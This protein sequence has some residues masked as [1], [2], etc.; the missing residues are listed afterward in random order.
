MSNYRGDNRKS[1]LDFELRVTVIFLTLGSIS[2]GYLGWGVLEATGI[3]DEI[4]ANHSQYAIQGG[5]LISLVLFG[6][7][8]RFSAANNQGRSATVKIGGILWFASTAL[9][10]LMVLSFAEMTRSTN[11]DWLQI[12]GYSAIIVIAASISW[13]TR[14]YRPRRVSGRR[15]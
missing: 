7:A 12:A 14:K 3:L 8:Y 9:A 2:L 13:I 1:P 10:G 4:Y 11:G 6:F 5:V 15:D